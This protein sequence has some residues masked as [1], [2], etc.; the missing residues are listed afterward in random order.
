MNMRIYGDFFAGSARTAK[1]A[2]PAL[3]LAGTLAACGGGSD[4]AAPE[5]AKLPDEANGRVA[6]T[7]TQA[8]LDIR[9]LNPETRVP[10][11]APDTANKSGPSVARKTNRVTLTLASE[12]FPPVVEGEVVQATSVSIKGEHGVVSY[13]MRGAPR[14]GAIDWIK[15]LAN[16]KPKLTSSATFNDSDVSAVI[17]DG[18]NIYAA[19]AT[20][21]PE[22]PFPSVLE[23]MQIQGDS[24]TLSG[25]ERMELT[26]FVATS[27]M[28]NGNTI[29]ATSGNTGGVFA[30]NKMDMTQLGEFPLSDAR[31]VA[32]DEAGQR[33]VVA[34]GGQPQGQISVFEEDAFPNGS[35]N[36]LNTFPFPGANVPESK[37]TVEI[38]GGKAFIAAGP[39]GVQVVCLD[40]GDVI[41]NV[42]RPDPGLLDPPL[43]D[44]V[45]VTNAVT[46]DD[47]LMFISNGEAGVYVATGAQGFNENNCNPQDITVLGKLRFDDLQ[48][49]NHVAYKN[50][51]LLVAAGLG[52]VKVVRVRT[53]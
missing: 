8:D 18:N 30:F 7:N 3:A 6:V 22:F 39:E 34:Q 12:V 31:W 10:I 33:I 43:P 40:T 29:Y 19:M 35:M 15:G 5:V 2:L 42:P 4:G 50:K 32:L 16:N 36:L 1:R 20:N 38:A 47:D 26:S 25:N 48:S 37:T 41:G 13:N 51:Y 46:V 17:V 14:L 53:D 27:V 24:L 49:A 28:E 44:E 45:V 11:D 23:R 21:A 9:V 52:G